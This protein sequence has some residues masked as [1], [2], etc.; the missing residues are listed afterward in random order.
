MIDLN[1]PHMSTPEA[2]KVS[3]LSKGY[4]S[5]LLRRGELE[6]FRLGRD[7]FIYTDSL[8]QFLEKPR[9]PGP[10]GPHKNHTQDPLDPPSTDSS[11]DKHG[12]D[13]S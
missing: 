13:K 7:W 4:L 8:Q 6:G 3:G 1:R 12:S 2:A 5:L 11:R 9:K 10:K